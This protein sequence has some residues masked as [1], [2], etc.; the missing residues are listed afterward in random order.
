MQKLVLLFFLVLPMLSLAQSIQW[1]SFIDYQYNQFGQQEYGGQ[2]V[3]GPPNAFPLGDLNPAAM[4]LNQSATFG[5]IIVGFEKPVLAKQLVIIE[6]YLPGALTSISLFDQQGRRYE[7]FNNEPEKSSLSH[8]ALWLNLSQTNQLVKKVEINISTIQNPGWSQIDAIGLADFDQKSDFENALNRYGDFNLSQPHYFTSA[9]KPVG[10]AINSYYVETKPIISPDGSTLYFVRQNYK[11]NVKGEK[12]PQDIYCAQFTNGKWQAAQNFGPPLN[13]KYANGVCSVSPD[14]NTLLLIYDQK[15]G[16]YMTGAAIS[17]KTR[18][19][20]SS[21]EPL[22]IDNFYNQ[23]K[24][25]DYFMGVN[26]K[27]LV[28]ALERNDSQ[29]K[30]D[31]YVSFKKD[32]LDKWTSPQNLGMGLNTPANDFAPFLAADNKTLY[33]ASEGYEGLGSSDIYYARRLDESWQNWS[34]PKNLGPEINSMGFDAYYTISAEGNR[35]YFVSTSNLLK[36]MEDIYQIDLPGALKPEPVVLISG[37]VY[38][39]YTKEPI[40]AEIFFEQLSQGNDDGI[41]LSNPDDGTYNLVLNPGHR[42]GFGAKASQ[43]MTVNEHLDLQETNSF[44]KIE[45]DLYLVPLK[46]G[47]VVQLNNIFFA[48]SKAVILPESYPELERLANTMMEHADLE[49]E[50]GG[51]TDSYGSAQ[52]NYEL[53]WQRVQAVKAFLADQGIEKNR[54]EVKGYGEKKPLYSNADEDKR[55]LNRRV[56]ITILKN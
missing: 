38:D 31:L 21:P 48:Q 41:A 22:I 30:Q 40:Q 53:S 15:K 37:T 10:A 13:D 16:K 39:A 5:T 32:G 6:N 2:Q 43:Y 12:D 4:K 20:W 14:G 46:V 24:Y 42:Y 18:S 54:I 23:S 3:L 26:G 7:C 11:G 35:A 49:I 51:H 56:E 1:A 36:E 34:K 47:Q 25:Q 33:F 44:K 27:V 8:R 29:G 55:K 9:K 45:R 52:A 28:M 19:G 50:L 17:R